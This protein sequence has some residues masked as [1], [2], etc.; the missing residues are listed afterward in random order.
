MTKQEKRE[1]WIAQGPAII[2]SPLKLVY[3]KEGWGSEAG[4]MARFFA[5]CGKGHYVTQIA[6]KSLAK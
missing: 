4:K 6:R 5:S 1:A 2:E 3:Q